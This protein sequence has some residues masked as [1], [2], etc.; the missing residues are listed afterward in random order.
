MGALAPYWWLEW[1]E[2]KIFV[3]YYSVRA[4]Q[5]SAGGGEDISTPAATTNDRNGEQ[6]ATSEVGRSPALMR[7]D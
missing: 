5:V 3:R 4:G 1:V 6:R 7:L 2:Q